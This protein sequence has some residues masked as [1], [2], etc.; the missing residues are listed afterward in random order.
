MKIWLSANVIESKSGYIDWLANF[1]TLG[2]ISQIIMHF[3]ESPL[4][5]VWMPYAQLKTAHAPLNVARTEGV[6]LFLSD[7]RTLVDGIASWWTACH[8]YNH[9]A[10]IQAINQQA[11]EMPHVM[12]GGIVNSQAVKLC[13]RLAQLIFDGSGRVFLCDSGSV[14]VE[15]SMKMAVQFWRNQGHQGRHKF[16]CFRDSYHGDTSGAMSVCD[17]DDS[18]H[19]HFKGFLLE[20]FP[21]PIPRTD[22]EFQQFE[23]FIVKN[24][25][26]TAGV[27]IEPLI[28]MAAGANFHSVE[29]L[30]RICEICQQHDLLFIADEVATGFGRTGSMFAFE[31]ANISP[32]IVCVGK[33]LTGGCIGMAATV[34]NEKVYAAF[35]HDDWSHALMHG[36]SFMGNPIACAAAN[37]SLDLFQTE[38]RIQQAMDLQESMTNQLQS[39][40]DDHRVVKIRT[41][42]AVAAVELNLA[43]NK[44]D[45]IQFFVEQGV[46]IRPI[47]KVVYLA[48]SFIIEEADLRQLTDA[49]KTFVSSLV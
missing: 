38:P 6:R 44:Y 34:A 41:R 12:M 36:P 3:D 7:G 43:F 11:A 4:K 10:L 5:H 23:E 8:G 1:S 15:V 35:H 19:S 22:S 47:G 17:P 39:L 31:Q 33:A 28:Q 9:P 48:P 27:I 21:C 29:S 32:D 26:S 49:I 13:E 2:T 18:M 20:Q 40:A 45:A 25:S 37:A 14:A 24:L 30:R 46:W 42:G 16:I